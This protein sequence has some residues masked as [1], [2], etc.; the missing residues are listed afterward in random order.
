MFQDRCSVSRK[1]KIPQSVKET[2]IEKGLICKDNEEIPELVKEII[3]ELTTGKK[4][5]WL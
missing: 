1:N 4:P 5:F 2:L 3:Y